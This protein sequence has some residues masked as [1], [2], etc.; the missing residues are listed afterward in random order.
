MPQLPLFRPAKAW[1]GFVMPFQKFQAMIFPCGT[2]ASFALCPCSK[3]KELKVGVTVG[4][5]FCSLSPSC[6]VTKMTQ[7]LMSDA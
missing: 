2:L 7:V 1:G 5:L 3:G 6:C 4:P